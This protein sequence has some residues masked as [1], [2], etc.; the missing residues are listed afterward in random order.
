MAIFGSVNTSFNTVGSLKNEIESLWNKIMSPIKKEIDPNLVAQFCQKLNS[1]I[2]A[3]A[4]NQAIDLITLKMQSNQ[5][6]EAYIALYVLEACVKNCGER[7]HD[8]IGRFRFL[9]EMIKLVSPK[10]YANR[11]SEK[12]KK[13]V[14]ELLYIWTECLSQ[15]K[16]KE[17]YQMLKN[18][19]IVASDPT[20]V[21]KIQIN[22]E[23]GPRIKHPIFEDDEKSKQLARLLKSKNPQDLEMAN[24][25]IKNMV[26]Q[27]EIKTEKTSNRINE[28]EHISNNMKL[29][30]E[31][32]LNYNSSNATESEMETIK[33]LYEELT[34]LRP[35][36]V[37]LA[38]E[39]DDNDD[40]IG[41]ILKTNDQCE[42]IINQYNAIFDKSSLS[43][44]AASFLKP[45]I[46][47]ND[48]NL[49]NLSSP[50]NSLLFDDDP[51]H[52]R[53]STTNASNNNNV[54]FDPLKELEDLFA[55]PSG[56]PAN[57][58][59]QN[60]INQLLFMNNNN[61]NQKNTNND[62]VSFDFTNFSG[63]N[64]NSIPSDI[65]GLIQPLITSNGVKQAKS[66]SSTT[67]TPKSV[68]QPTPQIKAIN[69][70]NELGRSL[71]EKSLNDPRV[72]LNEAVS[73]AAEK[74]QQQQQFPFHNI[75][76]LSLNEMHQQKLS[77][78]NTTTNTSIIDTANNQQSQ[79]Q[80]S[81]ANEN[82]HNSNTNEN[83]FQSLNSLEVKLEDIKPSSSAQPL[84]LYEKNSLKIVL[85]FATSAASALLSQIN[86]VVLTVTSSHTT[87]ALANFAFQAAVPKSMKVKLQ[88]A[89]RTDLPIS[90]P[91]LP[92]TAITQIMLI[93]NPNK[94]VI[95]L[96]Y[97]LSYS[98]DSVVYNEPEEV[99]QLPQLD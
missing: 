6:W 10:Y 40:A 57:T 94:D 25:L 89:S 79:Y 80:R 62:A 81:S 96:K 91:F 15:P 71:M 8:L 39:T 7:F 4:G 41:D 44:Q 46:I 95:R 85:H 22:V 28:L 33:Y 86:I 97:K 35:N 24:R 30:S 29:L 90:N 45:P 20:D 67:D 63:V 1:A 59:Q 16:I 98:F 26:R 84:T 61:N 31:M 78:T 42:K 48:V 74:Q 55:K 19:G 82:S 2:D 11:T 21:E 68:S 83:L 13:K 73:S 18:Q 56:N 32:L 43:L 17:A 72:S 64:S 3:D 27:D 66:N 5:E 60:Q 99:K 76:N 70:L 92:P 77:N 88:P 38:N 49:V 14:I 93:A 12:V 36:L 87:N 58:T 47:D 54:S 9:N 69:E 75:K 37:K 65:A 51:H 50:I 53:Y 34:K 23:V 52:Q